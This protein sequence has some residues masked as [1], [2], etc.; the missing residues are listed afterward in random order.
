MCCCTALTHACVQ[1][2]SKP[3]FG[4]E[5]YATFVAYD[6]TD[7]L[8]TNREN[9]SEGLLKAVKSSRLPHF[10]SLFD[11]VQVGM[12][13]RR[14][15]LASQFQSQLRQLMEELGSAHLQFIR[16]IKPNTM[17]SPDE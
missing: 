7:F 11:D 14:T 17:Q 10:V 6:V 2:K 13:A 9:F 15:S 16:T 8:N 3:L 12:A 1:D 5:H 4:V